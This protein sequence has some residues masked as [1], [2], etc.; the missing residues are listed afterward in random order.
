MQSSKT[1]EASRP[2]QT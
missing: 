1:Q 2:L